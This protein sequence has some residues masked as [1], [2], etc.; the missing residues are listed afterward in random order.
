MTVHTCPECCQALSYVDSLLRFEADSIDAPP[1]WWR[2][3]HPRLWHAA[4]V[5]RDYAR[6]LLHESGK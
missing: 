6:D 4:R 2:I 3:R 5:R 1:L